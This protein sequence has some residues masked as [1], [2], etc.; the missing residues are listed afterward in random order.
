M[1]FFRG[2]LY[3]QIIKRK[4]QLIKEMFLIELLAGQDVEI[5]KDLSH[6]QFPYSFRFYDPILLI[7]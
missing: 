6:K 7:I 4:I 3:L 2:Q 5:P 1:R